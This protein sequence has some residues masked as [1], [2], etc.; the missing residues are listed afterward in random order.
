M[1]TGGAVDNRPLEARADVLTYTSDVLDEPLTL[2]G[3]VTAEL[4]VSSTLDHTDWFVRLCDVHPDGRS[5]NVCDG[6][7][8]CTPSSIERTADGVFRV[9]VQ[10]WPAGHRFG[11]T[12]CCG[13][14]LNFSRR[15]SVPKAIGTCLVSSTFSPR[16]IMGLRQVWN[17][18]FVF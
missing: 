18:E 8:R 15:G 2:I 7:L 13:S 17:S 12:V 1:L 14:S 6:L 5:I 16:A 9:E 4:Y 10:V 11:A 3:P